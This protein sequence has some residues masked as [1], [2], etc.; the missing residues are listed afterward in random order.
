MK[1]FYLFTIRNNGECDVEIYSQLDGPLMKVSKVI[2]SNGGEISYERSSCKLV[3]PEGALRWGDNVEISY[4]LY[5]NRPNDLEELKAKGESIDLPIVDLQPSGTKFLK[6]VEI[7][8]SNNMDDEVE[9]IEFEFCEG[10]YCENSK[11][12]KAERA[13]T[14]EEARAKAEK[15]IPHVSYVVEKQETIAY[16]LSFTGARKKK[17][18]RPKESKRIEAN[19]YMN[20][21]TNMENSCSL[22]VYFCESKIEI[23]QVSILL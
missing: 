16:Y 4:T 22:A 7:H 10:R 23:K 12:L 6:P 18:N 2:S 11:W 14:R 9:D 13:E 8:L 3:I 17:K 15:K 1:K 21:Q 19:V 5:L 20:H